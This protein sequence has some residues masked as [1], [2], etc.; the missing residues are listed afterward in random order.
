MYILSHAAQ[1]H[2]VASYLLTIHELRE[3]EKF[4]RPVGYSTIKKH[5]KSLGIITTLQIQTFKLQ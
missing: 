4:S 5:I 2:A 3:D 1:Q